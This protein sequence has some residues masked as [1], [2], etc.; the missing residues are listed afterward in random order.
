MALCGLLLL[1]T[2]RPEAGITTGT[3]APTDQPVSPA[4]TSPEIRLEYSSGWGSGYL[5]ELDVKG[6]MWHFTDRKTNRRKVAR[7]PA[8]ATVLA[9]LSKA[10]E[11]IPEPGGLDGIVDGSTYRF[12]INHGE[13]RLVRSF[14]RPSIHFQC[15]VIDPPP[16][17]GPNKEMETVFAVKRKEAWEELKSH[18]SAFYLELEIDRILDGYFPD[19]SFT[20]KSKSR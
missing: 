20:V 2:C 12:T 10:L 19:S 13:K 11:E 9:C 5:L 4:P 3:P 8:A 14:G 15:R 18:W 17:A 6:E 1:S 16:S 7:E